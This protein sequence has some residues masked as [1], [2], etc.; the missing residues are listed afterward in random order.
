[1]AGEKVF[2][3][4]KKELKH[5]RKVLKGRRGQAVLVVGQAGMGKTWLMNRM[6][7]VVQNDPKL[8]CG[9]VHTK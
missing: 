1:M 2:V 9:C 3:G 4:R 5:L 8:R 7:E 6:A